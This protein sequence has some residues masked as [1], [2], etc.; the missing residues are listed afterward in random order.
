LVALVTYT[1]FA[2]TQR[3]RAS[4]TNSIMKLAKISRAWSLGRLSGPV[5]SCLSVAAPAR[6]GGWSPTA[7]S[8]EDVSA[9]AVSESFPVSTVPP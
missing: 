2:V 9:L 1:L 3:I 8:V 6:R 4:S 5:P 7:V